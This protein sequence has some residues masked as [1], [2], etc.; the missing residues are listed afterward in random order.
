[1]NSPWLR[2]IAEEALAKI[3]TEDLGRTQLSP[4]DRQH[5][6]TCDRCLGLVDGHRRAAL[7]LAA[8]WRFA[9]VGELSTDRDV[10]RIRVVV[11][12]GRAGF[13]LGR[14]TSVGFVVITLLLVV[15]AGSA[16]IVGASIPSLVSPLAGLPGASPSPIASPTLRATPSLGPIDTS[17]WQTFE[18]NLYG[19]TMSRPVD[20]RVTP[21]S[22]PEGLVDDPDTVFGQSLDRLTARD[23]T[24]TFAAF[25]LAIPDGMTADAFIEAYR[26]PDVEAHGIECFP[27]P[28]TWES[29]LIDGHIAWLVQRCGTTDAIVVADHR[30]YSF[31]GYGLLSGSSYR[32]MFDAFLSTVR[33]EPGRAVN[34]WPVASPSPS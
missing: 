24:A 8:P 5:L 33:L 19:L 26:A 9:T 20:W 18:S 31:T 28:P 2:H 13:G 7:V 29:M 30:A 23:G 12:S 4:S 11:S 15:L 10:E 17:T 3:A 27:P 22:I 6:E 16:V 21:A 34:A 32:R 14:S 25:S 1:M